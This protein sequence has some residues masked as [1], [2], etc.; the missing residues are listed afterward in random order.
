INQRDAVTDFVQY[1]RPCGW[2]IEP[3]GTQGLVTCNNDSDCASSV[4]SSFVCACSD[5]AAVNAKGTTAS[6]VSCGNTGND[7][8]ASADGSQGGRCVLATCRDDVANFHNTKDCANVTGDDLNTCQLRACS[9]S[10]EQCKV[11]ACVD[12]SVGALV[13]GRIVMLGR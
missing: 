12:S 13:D 7:C 1:G 5:A 6:S 9:E 10:G 11:L 8:A 2:Q 4:G 3:D